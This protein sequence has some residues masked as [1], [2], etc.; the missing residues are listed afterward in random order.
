MNLD[1]EPDHF[2]GD[3]NGIVSSHDILMGRQTLV[4]N[5]R[6]PEWLFIG[7]GGMSD[8]YTD[9]VL[10]DNLVTVETLLRNVW[11]EDIDDAIEQLE[12]ITNP[13]ATG[14]MLGMSI[15]E[16]DKMNDI[17]V[18]KLNRHVAFIM[19]SKDGEPDTSEVVKVE[20]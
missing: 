1:F 18:N 10:S 16:V 7:P 17:E 15:I 14:L 4:E 13:N 19:P 12:E 9:S 20:Y 3:G 8:I 5:G 11:I 2:V 6:T